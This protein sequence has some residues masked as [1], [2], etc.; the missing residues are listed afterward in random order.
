[1]QLVIKVATLRHVPFDETLLIFSDQSQ[2]ILGGGQT[3][4]SPKNVNINVT[5]EFEASLGAKPV[6]QVVMFIF[7]LTKEHFQEYE[8]SL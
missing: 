1:M 7:L 6:G 4:L 2:F 3:F 8:S 5:T